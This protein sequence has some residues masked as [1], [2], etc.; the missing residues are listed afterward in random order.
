LTEE[1]QARQTMLIGE[2]KMAKLQN[3]RVAVI[4]LGGV[5]G[6]V[7]EG[8]VRAGVGHLLFIDGDIVSTTNINRQLI[9]TV[10][11]IG[12][13]K[14]ETAKQRALSINPVVNIETS[15]CTIKQGVDGG[16]LEFAPHYVVDAIDTISA[17]LFLVEHCK[18]NKLP[19]L[20]CM[21]TGNRTMFDGFTI[22]DIS[23]TKGTSCPVARVIRKELCK[24]QIENVTVLYNKSPMQS[25]AVETQNGRHAPGSIAYMPPIAG[26]M[27]AGYVIQQL[28]K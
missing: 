13:Q 15:F 19:L 18:A 23:E 20:C 28:I 5:G 25:T 14:V 12:M 27:A 22:A 16:L 21:G 24:R 6:A 4:G 10:E 1:W 7:A 8:L 3:S 9:A 17:K 26:F 2:A 11:T